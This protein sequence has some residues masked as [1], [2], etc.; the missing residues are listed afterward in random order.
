MSSAVHPLSLPGELE[1]QIRATAKETRLSMAD[2]IRQS[3]KLGLPTLRQ[4][5][6]KSDRVTNVDPLPNKVAR[7][8]YAHRVDDTE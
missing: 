7:K 1:K 5:L 3:I 2:V 4:R 6:G 8:L